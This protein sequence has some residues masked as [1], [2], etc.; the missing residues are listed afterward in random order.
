[1]KN[2]SFVACILRNRFNRA[3][4]GRMSE[5]KL[6]DC[7]LVSGALFQTVWNILSDFPPEHGIKDYDVFYFDPDTSWRAEDTAIRRA[8][9]VFADL[10]VEIEV[11]NQARVHLWYEEKF[12]A[13][14]PP[15]SRATEGIDR[16][17]A[18]NSQVGVRLRGDS[19]ELYA[20]HGL[21]DV[22]KM[23][24]RPNPTA[25][26]QTQRYYEKANRWKTQWPQIT[27]EPA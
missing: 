15:L 9:A 25:N 22:E 12:A 5:L 27:I 10:C 18:V 20:P 3:I 13:P 17:L 26:F 19:F 21:D 8:K 24:V 6:P 4:L 14:Y 1:M 2:E 16:F 7:W 11:R 23:L